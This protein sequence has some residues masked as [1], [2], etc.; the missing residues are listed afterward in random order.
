MAPKFCACLDRRTARTL[1]LLIGIF[2][3]YLNNLHVMSY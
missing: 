2:I 1:I 3:S